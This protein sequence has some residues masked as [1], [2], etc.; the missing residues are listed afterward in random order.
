ML[1]PT[2][3]QRLNY[4]TEWMTRDEIVRATYDGALKLIGLKATHGVIGREEAGETQRHIRMARELIRRM[5]D[6][7]VIDD[8]LKMEI[9]RLN[10]L[11]FLCGKH[12]LRWPMNGWKLNLKNL[13]RLL[14]G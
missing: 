2:W 10:R 5:E 3:K 12:E 6:A 1:M 11:D 13:F 14:V 4:E 8:A 9:F 7:P